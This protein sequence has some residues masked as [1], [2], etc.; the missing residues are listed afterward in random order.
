[1]ECFEKLLELY[2]SLL[3]LRRNPA[4]ETEKKLAAHSSFSTT[5]SDFD[6]FFNLWSAGC[7]LMY[8][9]NEPF[10]EIFRL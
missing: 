10:P 4:A 3:S 2:R 9:G 1:M 8:D 5:V 7:H 6:L